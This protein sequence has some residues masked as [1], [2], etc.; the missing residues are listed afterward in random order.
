MDAMRVIRIKEYGGPD[1]MRLEEVPTPEPGPGQLRVRVEAAGVNFIDTYQRRGQYKVPLPYAMGLEGAGT[2]EATGPGVRGVASGDR[3]AWAQAPG[4]YASH[5]LVE[6]ERAVPVPEDIEASQAAAAMLQGLTAHY[7]A[8]STYPLKPGEA[9]LVH[10]AAGGVGLLLTQIA[11]RCG[12]RVIA[13]VGTEDKARL[14]RDAGADDII[15]YRHEDFAEATRRLTGGAGVQVV[16]DSVGR[17]TFER[18]LK[19][20]AP[21]GM[22]VLYGQS[23][24]SV[25]PFDPQV[26]NTLGSLFLT[27]PSLGHYTRTRDELR[28]RADDVFAW[29]ADGSLKLRIGATF[30]LEQATEAHRQLEGRLTTGKLLL[31]P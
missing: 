18:S 1:V 21:R 6:A 19:I 14:A 29:I 8:Y 11:K 3:V 9:C 25:P 23:S 31:L 20:L 24:G 16:Y 27:R 4:S 30:P 15:L 13:T 2:V 5:V 10:A 26:L 12:A 7:L 22:L 28:S 17:D